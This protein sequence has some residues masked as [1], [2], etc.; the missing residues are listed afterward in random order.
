[1]CPRAGAVTGQRLPDFGVDWGAQKKIKINSLSP[2][3]SEKKSLLKMLAQKNSLLSK[4]MKNMLTRKN[5]KTYIIGIAY[6]KKKI[7]HFFDET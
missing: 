5:T 2:Q 6:D 4:L 3:K 1:M 7:F